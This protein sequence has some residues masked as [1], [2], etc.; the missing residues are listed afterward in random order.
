VVALG[1]SSIA[2]AVIAK[3]EMDNA[4]MLRRQE[5]GTEKYACHEMCGSAIALYE[6][7]NHC[8]EDAFLVAYEYCL[9]CAGP[10]DQDIWS[11]YGTTLR[12]AGKECGFST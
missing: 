4:A 1:T 9:L 6:A 3:D 8:D 7:G 2:L 10:G 11:Y 12:R 5:P